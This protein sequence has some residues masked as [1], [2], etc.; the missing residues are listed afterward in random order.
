MAD[1]KFIF[2]TIYSIL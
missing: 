1:Q 2:M